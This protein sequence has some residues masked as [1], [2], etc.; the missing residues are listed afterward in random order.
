MAGAKQMRERL[1]RQGTEAWRRATGE[2]RGIYVCP[3]CGWGFTPA[4]LEMNPPLLSLED[5]PTRAVGGRRLVLTCRKCNSKAGHGIDKAVAARDEARRIEDALL[6]KKTSYTRPGRIELEG[7]VTNADISITPLATTIIVP[8]QRN[9]PPIRDEQIRL[10]QERTSKRNLNFTLS[11]PLPGFSERKARL[12]DLKSAYLA[13]FAVFGYHLA[14][15]PR[16]HIV[17]RQLWEPDSELITQAWLPNRKGRQG[18]FIMKAPVSCLAVSL[19]LHDV[20]LPWIEGPDDAYAAVAAAFDVD[21]F[22]ATVVPYNWPLRPEMLI[23]F[24]PT[25]P[26]GCLK[27]ALS[28]E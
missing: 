16:M 24:D 9:N 4:A 25:V 26:I 22:T 21:H 18:V 7:L 11:F 1:F 19:R 23:D 27:P 28:F 13:A 14:F 12:G 10:W 20:I 5:V 8:V 15:H 3:L 17:R 6:R 2:E